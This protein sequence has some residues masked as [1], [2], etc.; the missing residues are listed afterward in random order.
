MIYR[1]GG[2]PESRLALFVGFGGSPENR[3]SRA[4]PERGQDGRGRER[5]CSALGKLT[6]HH[7]CLGALR[8]I[9]SRVIAGAERATAK[10]MLS[11]EDSTWFLDSSKKRGAV[12][13][14][15]TC[16]ANLG[17]VLFWQSKCTPYH[18]RNFNRLVRLS[19][20]VQNW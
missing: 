14:R 11:Y 8:H 20:N 15:N 10:A 12:I 5:P 16:R 6:R 7:H 9:S 18:I 1:R 19:R 4:T 3:G 13:Y 2:E 17:S